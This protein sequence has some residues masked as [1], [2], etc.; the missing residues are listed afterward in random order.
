MST[1]T[2][3]LWDPLQP[4]PWAPLDFTRYTAREGRGLAFSPTTADSQSLRLALR[5]RLHASLV[6]GIWDYGARTDPDT[7]VPRYPPRTQAIAPRTIPAQSWHSLLSAR[8]P[9][10]QAPTKM[11]W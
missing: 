10:V 3:G 1:T 11:E 8:T 7:K 5:P 6:R 4:P 9:T 2:L